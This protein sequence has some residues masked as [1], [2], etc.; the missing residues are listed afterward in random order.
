[1]AVREAILAIGRW[2]D[3]Q[4]RRHIR[5]REQLLKDLL[6]APAEPI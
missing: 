4:E 1:M 5:S 3:M 6:E 2:M